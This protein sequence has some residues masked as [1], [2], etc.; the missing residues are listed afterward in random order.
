MIHIVAALTKDRVIGRGNNMP[1]RIQEEKDLFKQLTL[2]HPVI[3][4]ER[5]F[6]SLPKPLPKRINIVISP[7][8]EPEPGIV[9]THSLSDALQAA[10]NIDEEIFVIGGAEVYAQSLELADRLHLSW[11]K[12]PYEGDVYFPAFD[13]ARWTVIEEKPF[14]EFTYKQYKKKR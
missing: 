5:T 2:N 10:Q 9:I 11:I 14:A 1:W 3:M 8:R 6:A 12:K 13:E 7:T 4:G